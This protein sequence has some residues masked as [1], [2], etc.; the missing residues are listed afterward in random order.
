MRE[1]KGE[2]TWNFSMRTLLRS[3]STGTSFFLAVGGRKEGR[4]ESARSFEGTAERE[5]RRGSRRTPSDG[6]SRIDVVDLRTVEENARKSNSEARRRKE[7]RKKETRRLTFPTKPPLPPV[8][9]QRSSWL[10]CEKKQTR[11]KGQRARKEKRRRK[12][13]RLTQSSHPTS[14]SL[15]RSTPP[16]PSSSSASPSS[17]WSPP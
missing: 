17:S 11:R 8:C 9:P 16:S 3:F 7:E 5:R 4:E 14:Q 2:R 10:D 12:E 6:N 1:E 15:S 13:T